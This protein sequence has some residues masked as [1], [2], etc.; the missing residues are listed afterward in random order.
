LA[1]IGGGSIVSA[2]IASTG[3]IYTRTPTRALRP[4]VDAGTIYTEPRKRALSYAILAPNPHNRQPWLVDLSKEGEISLFVDTSKLLPHT[5]PFSRQITIGL[6][7]FLEL[8]RM[9]AAQ[10]GYRASIDAFPDGYTNKSLDKRLIA[11]VK[12]QKDA[13]IKKDTLFAHVLNRRTLREMYD[14]ERRVPDHVLEK[15]TEVVGNGVSVGTTN[16]E[17]RVQRV[18]DLT[19]QATE[20]EMRTPRTNKESIDL[21]RI[22]K[23]EIEAN[24]DGISL[25]GAKFEMLNAAGL[26]SI[27]DALEPGTSTFQQTLA[28]LLAKGDTAMGYIWLVTKTNT[29]LDQLNAGRDWIRINL[30]TTA[31]GVGVH[32]MS[33]ALQEYGEMSG[34]Y[35]ECHKVLA[36]DGGTVQML[37]RL[38]YAKHVEPS[39]RW[40]LETKIIKS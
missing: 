26:M 8:L 40:A 32:P 14:L 10:D 17:T 31:Q 5:D 13:S 25:S 2:G 7:C 29:R 30:A 23:S 22:G 33:Q 4:W 3:F 6:G 21:V 28:G 36:P 35:K 1:V 12:I 18:R 39:P 20:I 34:L 24:P 11:R 19:H 38:G 37:G 15:L 27:Q 16:D 9:A